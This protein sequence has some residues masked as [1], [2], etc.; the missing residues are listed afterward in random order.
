[1]LNKMLTL[2][3]VIPA[4][5]CADELNFKYWN[6]VPPAAEEPEVRITDKQMVEDLAHIISCYK[7]AADASIPIDDAQ[8]PTNSLIRRALFHFGN[9]G[10]RSV[11]TGL[12][13]S[14]KR[15]VASSDAREYRLVI[16]LDCV[17]D[18]RRPLIV[19]DRWIFDGNKWKVDFYF[20]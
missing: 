8:T 3:C 15:S 6:V 12:L 7:A 1:M 4:V 19:V 5:L 18:N 20:N 13:A 10:H 9:E 16:A 17:G 14:E 11:L 2:L